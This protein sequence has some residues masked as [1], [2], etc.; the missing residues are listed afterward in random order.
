MFRTRNLL[1]ILTGILVLQL[2]V[3]I[4]TVIAT[5]GDMKSYFIDSSSTHF[6][7]NQKI[8][9]IGTALPFMI[10][11][12]FGIFLGILSLTKD[13]NHKY[14]AGIA[15][16]SGLVEFGA[17]LFSIF[18]ETNAK[19]NLSLD[20]YINYIGYSTPSSSILNISTIISIFVAVGLCSFA[21]IILS[22]DE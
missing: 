10:I 16:L 6:I 8:G 12:L 22:K 20:E 3:N 11:S 21:S 9:I 1:I 17:I 5:I 14:I 19:R 2:L 4:V 18:Q 15:L 7:N 13:M